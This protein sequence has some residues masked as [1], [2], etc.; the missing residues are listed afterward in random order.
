MPFKTEK[1]SLGDFLNC[2]SIIKIAV[3][4]TILS[5]YYKL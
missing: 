4:T 1:S 5:P 3:N 2:Q